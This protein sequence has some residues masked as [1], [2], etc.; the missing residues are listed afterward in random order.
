[1]KRVMITGPT[2]S[3][4]TALAELLTARG[5]EVYTICRPGSENICLLK[6]HSCLHILEKDISCLEDLPEDL[7]GGFDAFFHLAWSGTF[8]EARNAPDLQMK[9]I[10]YTLEAVKVAKDLGCKVFV[11]AG[12]QAE[13]GHYDQPAGEKTPPRPFT[14]YGAAKLA[15]GHMSS[16]YGKSLGIRHSWVRIFSVFGPGDDPGTLASTLIREFQKGSS[17]SLT[18]GEQIWDFLYSYDA[19]EALIAV[20]EKGQDGAFYSLGSGEQ[21]PLRD[22]VL[23]MRDLI[24]PRVE[25]GFGEKPYG[26][27]QVMFLSADSTRLKKDTG[28]TPRYTFA[29]GIQDLLNRG[30]KD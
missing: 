9:N 1:M 21:K 12:S 4:G 14:L 13:F 2:G 3:I 5:C 20:A 26:E 19:A 24:D 16:V 8:G 6:E 15:A 7:E 25:I 30:I 27:N 23:E 10:Q 29:E 17:P 28:F 11:G 22:Y 18:K